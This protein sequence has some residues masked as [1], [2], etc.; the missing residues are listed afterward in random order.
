MAGEISAVTQRARA[1]ETRLRV[2][3]E[4]WGKPLI[5]SQPWVAE[6]VEAA[7]GEFIGEAGQQTTVERVREINPD[8]IV[9]AW[10]GAG[11]RVPLEKV[12][13]ER[14]WG[15]LDAVRSGRVFCIS[16][17]LLNTPAPTLVG[18]L[19]A[20]AHALHPELFP[21]ADGLRSMSERRGGVREHRPR[22]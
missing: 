2:Y 21:A 17:E 18:G 6:L 13:R 11:D 3:C 1:A 16:D 7:G 20:L 15:E 9:C 4:E 19:R 12:V 22:V 14:G 5:H 8:V 10:C